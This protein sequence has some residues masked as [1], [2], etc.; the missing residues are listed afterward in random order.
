MLT[1]PRPL[2]R[3][4]VRRGHDARDLAALDDDSRLGRLDRDLVLHR[5]RRRTFSGGYLPDVH[6]LADDAAAG[7][8][9]IAA[10]DA[11]Q[12]LLVLLPLLLLRADEEEVEDAQ[13]EDDLDQE[14]RRT[15]AGTTELEECERGENVRV[16]HAGAGVVRE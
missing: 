13:D 1:A 11:A 5:T 8:D 2:L 4:S 14:V 16:H 9:P 15:R 6:D 10:L 12:C 3:G 7:D